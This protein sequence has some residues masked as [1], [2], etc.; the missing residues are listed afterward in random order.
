MMNVFAMYVLRESNFF[1]DIKG[2]LLYIFLG[3]LILGILWGYISMSIARNKGYSEPDEQNKWFLIGFVLGVIGIII[4]ACQPDVSGRSSMNNQGSGF[5]NL[6]L[7]GNNVNSPKENYSSADEIKKFKELLDSG[8]ITEEEFQA[9]KEQL[10][11][12]RK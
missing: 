7:N 8:V 4:A 6:N 3:A 11:N 9:K 1:E 10:L 2:Y 12:N 5:S